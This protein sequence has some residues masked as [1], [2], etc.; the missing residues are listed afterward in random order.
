MTFGQANRLWFDEGRTRA[1][2]LAYEDAHRAA[3][4]DPVIAF[5]LARALWALDRLVEARAM[6]DTADA[7]RDALSE[8][9]LRMLDYWRDRIGQRPVSDTAY[10]ADMLDRDTLG[11]AL[12]DDLDWSAIADA[13]AARR[14]FG[15]AAY[16]LQRWNGVPIDADDAEEIGRIETNRHLDQVA[17]KAMY[18]RPSDTRR[19]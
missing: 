19:R 11:H 5:Q 17:L 12:D 15:V 3:P 13:A 1:A 4:N 10:P 18:G 9:G 6:F 2:L 8:D 14:M 16:A 7:H